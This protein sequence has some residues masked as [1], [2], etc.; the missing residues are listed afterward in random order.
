[1][2][3][4]SPGCNFKAIRKQLGVTQKVLADAIGCVQANITRSERC[5][6]VSP[7]IA[8]KLIDFCA[9]RGL[10]ITFD[11]IYGDALYSG[12]GTRAVRSVSSRADVIR[13]AAEALIAEAV[14]EEREACRLAAKKAVLNL[15][16]A[17]VSGDLCHEAIDNAIRARGQHG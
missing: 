2:V 10:A 14:A 16:D 12:V 4:S 1:M 8:R 17:R 7:A 13:L 6:T 15:G 5:G 9:S 3:D 11:H